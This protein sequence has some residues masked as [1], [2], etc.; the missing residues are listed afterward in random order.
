MPFGKTHFFK[1]RRKEHCGTRRQEDSGKSVVCV[2]SCEREDF[3]NRGI[4]TGEDVAFAGLASFGAGKNPLRDVPYIDKIITAAHCCR[5]TMTA[6]GKQKTGDRSA[7]DVSRTDHAGRQHDA[8]RQS[9]PGGIEDKTG[10]EG[11]A[12]CV[13]SVRPPHGVT[14]RLCDD[15][16]VRSFG[17]CV[18][19]ADVDQLRNVTGKTEVCDILCPADIHLIQFLRRARRYGDHACAMDQ[20][21]TTRFL[22]G[23]EKSLQGSFV[24]NIAEDRFHGSRQLRAQRIICENQSRHASAAFDE[25]LGEG[26]SQKSGGTGDKIVIVHRHGESSLLFYVY[27]WKYRC[28]I[29]P[30]SRQKHL[31][32]RLSCMAGMYAK[33]SQVSSCTRSCF[34]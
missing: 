26:F 15:L 24:G 23:I 21:G 20:T 8:G 17:K 31:A 11:L 9:A 5:K 1:E 30:E 10:R 6:K 28:A 25:P 27:A 12:F 22:Y 13:R 7:R 32:K 29:F 3:P 16:T 18:N 34:P 19:R 2:V 14:S 33:E 4:M